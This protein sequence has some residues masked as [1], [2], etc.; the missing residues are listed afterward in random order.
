M[1]QPFFHCT[2]S[3]QSRNNEFLTIKTVVRKTHQNNGHTGSSCLDKVVLAQGGGGTRKKIQLLGRNPHTAA[4]IR[5]EVLTP[6]PPPEC[7]PWGLLQ[8][9][10]VGLCLWKLPPAILRHP[11]IHPTPPPYNR[12]GGRGRGVKNEKLIGG[13]FC[14]PKR[15]FYKGLEI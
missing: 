15:S 11:S 14:L 5:K 8:N 6:P 12:Y 13:S 4:T 2:I 9:G 3:A 1:T 10:T 7:C